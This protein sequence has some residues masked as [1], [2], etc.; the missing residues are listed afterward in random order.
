MRAS[1]GHDSKA[2]ARARASSTTLPPLSP[3]QPSRALPLFDPWMP[4]ASNIVDTLRLKAIQNP[5]DV[6]SKLEQCAR[7]FAEVPRSA[8]LVSDWLEL[9]P[10]LGVIATRAAYTGQAWCALTDNHRSWL[11]LAEAPLALARERGKTV[12]VISQYDEYGELASC[13]TW[14]ETRA[15]HWETVAM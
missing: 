2:V 12:L 3:S 6:Q 11:F 13:S 14:V 8:R 5:S 15:S 1:Y 4:A 7:S 9:P 10:V